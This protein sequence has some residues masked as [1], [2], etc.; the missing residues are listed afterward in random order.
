VSIVFDWDKIFTSAF[1]RGLFELAQVQLRLSYAYHP[2]TDGQIEHVNQC[3][4]MFLCCFVS[5]CPR[6]WL[7]WLY[8]AEY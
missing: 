4:E 6:K 2:Q 7:S 8:L 1:W 5:A 3:M